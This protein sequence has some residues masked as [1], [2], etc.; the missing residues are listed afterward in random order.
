VAGKSLSSEIKPGQINRKI[1]MGSEL[2]YINR[3][4]NAQTLAGKGF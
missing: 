1:K 4:N 2:R 3:E